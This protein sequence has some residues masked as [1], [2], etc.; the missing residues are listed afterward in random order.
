MQRVWALDILQHPVKEFLKL[1]KDFFNDKHADKPM[2]F[3]V[4]TDNVHENEALHTIR[5]MVKPKIS[6]GRLAKQII[7]KGIVG[8]WNSSY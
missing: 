1:Y 4:F 2:V 8:D 7:A 3:E 5:Y 6:P